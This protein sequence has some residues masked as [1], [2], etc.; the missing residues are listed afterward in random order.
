MDNRLPRSR[1]RILLVAVLVIALGLLGRQLPGIIGDMMGGLLY[2]V[3]LYLL[4]A[5]VMPR[6]RPLTLTA[7]AA[8]TGIAIEL[9]QLTGIPAQIG[10]AWPPAKLVL[11]ST[12][13]PL[14]LLVA[15]V[16]AACG[17]L[18]DILVRGR[19]PTT[20]KE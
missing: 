8:A 7:V 19:W 3:L 15:A 9:F 17:P 11:G 2:A 10:A 18:A 14:D 4:F 6:A 1:R 20:A 12:F 13:V 16:G 5:F